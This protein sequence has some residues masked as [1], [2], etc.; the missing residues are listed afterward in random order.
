M[1]M[2]LALA[3]VRRLVVLDDAGAMREHRRACF[4]R[5]GA[6]DSCAAGNGLQDHRERE[7]KRAERRDFHFLSRINSAQFIAQLHAIAKLQQSG[8]IFKSDDS[9]LFVTLACTRGHVSPKLRHAAGRK[10]FPFW[11]DRSKIQSHVYGH[12]Q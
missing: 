1:P 9:A 7:H 2:R 4:G 8:N 12:H 11:A 10:T 6:R 3:A 5:C